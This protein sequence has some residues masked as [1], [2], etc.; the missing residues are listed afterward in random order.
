M[1]YG[2]AM[3]RTEQHI[4]EGANSIPSIHGF[5]G[6]ASPTAGLGGRW[7]HVLAG[8]CAGRDGFCVVSSGRPRIRTLL[9]LVLG[10]TLCPSQNY[11]LCENAKHSPSWQPKCR[12]PAPVPVCAGRWG[13]A[14]EAW[15]AVAFPPGPA[16]LLSTL[17]SPQP[18]L[19][20]AWCCCI[21]K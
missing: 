1:S 19:G 11:W 14:T 18:A 4:S 9:K 21:G 20:T 10:S 17:P 6:R 8:G 3:P 7:L 12:A 16:A 13:I 2:S 15:L 5:T